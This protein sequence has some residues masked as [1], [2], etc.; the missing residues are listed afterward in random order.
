MYK[1][2]VPLECLYNTEIIYVL[3]NRFVYVFEIRRIRRVYRTN[4]LRIDELEMMDSGQF[5]IGLAVL[6]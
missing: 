4:V 5:E 2:L 6:G 3:Y 1:F